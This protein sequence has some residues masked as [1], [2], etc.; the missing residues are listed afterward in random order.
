MFVPFICL[1]VYKRASPQVA[2]IG[3][4][5]QKRSLLAAFISLA[6]ITLIFFGFMMHQIV[7]EHTEKEQHFLLDRLA[8][9]DVQLLS[10][11]WRKHQQIKAVLNEFR[12]Q[13]NLDGSYLIIVDQ[14][15]LIQNPGLN[16]PPRILQYF[17]NAKHNLHD[18]FGTAKLD[19]VQFSWS[20]YTIAQSGF[21]LIYALDMTGVDESPMEAI[22]ARLLV[23][24]VIILWLAVW[25]ALTVF[26]IFSRRT[27]G[28]E[29]ARIRSEMQLM[30]LMNSTAEAILSVDRQG[31]C[32]FCNK[33]AVS[34]L[35]A[36]A[37][38]QLLG[39]NMFDV[40]RQSV[41]DKSHREDFSLHQV[42]RDNACESEELLL[43][44]AGKEIPVEMRSNPVEQ[45]GKVTGAV[46]T[47]IDISDKYFVQEE[48]KKLS[49]VVDRSSDGVFITDSVGI[50]EYLN[51]AFENM[52][53]L[54]QEEILGK[55]FTQI[56]SFG[57]DDNKIGEIW[58]K[59][60]AG[61]SSSGLR[62]HKR[63]DGGEFYAK[64]IIVPIRDESA[65]IKNIVFTITDV[66]L[67][68]AQEEQIQR[69]IRE[70]QEAESANRAK[71][72]FLARMSHELRTPLNAIIGYSE[73]LQEELDLKSVDTSV[74]SDLEKI[75]SAGYYLLNLI[76]DILDYSKIEAGKVV[77]N[78]EVCT[79][80]EILHDVVGMVNPLIAK[81]NNKLHV[82][83]QDFSIAI[84]VDVLRLRQCLYNLLSNAAKFTENG[85]IDLKVDSYLRDDK[86]WIRFEVVDTGIGIEAAHIK[87][88]FS[89]FYQTRQTAASKYGG[90]GLGL[91]IT[92][93][94][95]RMMGGDVT[96]SSVKGK[97][98]HF[99][100][101]LPRVVRSIKEVG[102]LA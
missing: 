61:Q 4:F 12:S 71:S 1:P 62:I 31:V 6:L 92:Q 28:L 76:S 22:G 26:G 53:G 80:K 58:Q 15:G 35:G 67:H 69:T 98:A 21:E 54:P 8:K 10:E 84:D 93:R 45:Q 46:I 49:L 25:L 30:S 97:G 13:G 100:I 40:L 66:S 65:G 42:I 99:C 74:T 70:K 20:R 91:A 73:L 19:D 79:V 101:E 32:T 87:S 34:L 68:V 44:R 3:F 83:V 11:L 48:M 85:T 57:D 81:N 37:D 88:L 78:W 33:A 77:F 102:R 82:D 96:V 90:T 63:S 24:A 89:E 60:H 55:A 7:L 41:A 17:S 51:P 23:S 94:L 75:Q 59:I 95:C 39:S 27:H 43:N 9:R 47:L 29:Q 64:E 5:M 56:C 86:E 52:C 72:S 38:K 2:N 14:H 18:D 16:I 50:I 36:G